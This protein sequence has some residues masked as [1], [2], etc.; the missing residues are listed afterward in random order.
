[1]AMIIVKPK[2]NGGYPVKNKLHLIAA[3]LMRFLLLLRS[4]GSAVE[5]GR[6][7]SLVTLQ[8]RSPL[9]PPSQVEYALRPSVHVHASYQR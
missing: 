9:R 5:L 8:S 6:L 7:V 3:M 4:C 1:M 2:E